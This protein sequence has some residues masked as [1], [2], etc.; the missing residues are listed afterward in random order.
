MFDLRYHVASL[1]A[2]FL[3]LVIGILVGVGL[4]GRGFV[5]EAERKNLTGQIADLRRERDTALARLEATQAA[6]AALEDYAERTYPALVPRRLEG[7]AVALV[8][9]GSVDQAVVSAV[10]EAVRDAGGT[11]DRMRALRIPLDGGAVDD[12]LRGRIATR[13]FVGADQRVALGRELGRELMR[14]GPLPLWTQLEGVIVEERS[15]E[16]RT[17]VDGVVVARP[18]APQQGETQDFLSG[19]YGGL[20]RVGRPAVGIDTSSGP[21]PAIPAFQRAG[22][23]TVD[24]VETEA[25]RLALVLLLAGAPAGS[26]GLE[27]GAGDGIV[28]TVAPVTPPSPRE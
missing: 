3:A 21:F 25:G 13:T 12:A 20:V 19:L 28:P 14:G 17:P 22:L 4:S 7:K 9:A 11:I 5:G 2:V 24:S 26:Y 10:T 23:S 27:G 15:G 6:G 16:L 1:A 8:F 18:I